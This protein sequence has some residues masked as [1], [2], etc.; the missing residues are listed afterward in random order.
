MVQFI[1]HNKTTSKMRIISSCSWAEA[2]FGCRWTKERVS[3][4]EEKRVWEL[5]WRGAWWYVKA[6]HIWCSR[7]AHSPCKLSFRAKREV[8]RGHRAVEGVPLRWDASSSRV[9]PSLHLR[10]EVGQLPKKQTSWKTAKDVSYR[11]RSA[12]V[13]RQSCSNLLCKKMSSFEF[14]CQTINICVFYNFAL[15]IRK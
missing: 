9:Q 3:R 8:Q 10:V 1:H 6:R 4:G 5:R 15:N 11:G 14:V 7:W 12:D 2:D 13:K